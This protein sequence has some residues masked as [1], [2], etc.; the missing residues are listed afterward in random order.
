M[1]TI[2]SI[3]QQAAGN[4]KKIV[5]PETGD[6]RILQAAQLIKDR[7]IAQPLLTG[8]SDQIIRLAEDNDINLQHI[9]IIDL[10]RGP[11]T[12]K[13]I[14]T[15]VE[16][17][18]HKG[19]TKATA[20]EL[21][22]S[23]LTHA[24]CMV[25]SGDADGCVAGAANTTSDVVRAALQVI[26]MNNN[27]SMVSSFF[28]MQHNLP[29]QAIQG[30]AVFADCG[31]VI[32]PD[33]EQLAQIAMQSAHS[34]HNLLG[35]T[36]TVALLSFSTAGSASHPSVDKVKEAGRLIKS[37]NPDMKLMVEV[38]FDAAIL[39]E[40]LKSKAPEIEASAP[41]NVFIFPDLQSGNIGYK[42]AQ[43][44]GGVE[45]IGPILQ[46][47]A[48]PVN[49]LSRGCSVDDIVKLVAVTSVQAS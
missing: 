38:Q 18:K 37:T 12:A 5:L 40:V 7:G 42:I 8:N 41:A 46:G 22:L 24:V 13:Y 14:D 33:A 45:A 48:S 35:I 19:M 2:E 4:N 23:P 6:I 47:L 27:S 43:R 10:E 1:N 32:E 21:I 3:I 34:A 20:S 26:G 36:P 9:D 39:P 17:R 44:L 28:L 15:L 31:L 30:A 11:N 16:V 49:D 25:K 29:H